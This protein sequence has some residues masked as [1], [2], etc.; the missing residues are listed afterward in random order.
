M[1]APSDSTFLGFKADPALVEMLDQGRGSVSRSQ[2][3]REAVAEK[4]D[5]PLSHASAP[6]RKGKGGPKGSVKPHSKPTENSRAR[7]KAEQ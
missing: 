4:L 3:I 5:V 6:D 1:P 2:F 7:R